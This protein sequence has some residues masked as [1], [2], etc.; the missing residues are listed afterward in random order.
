MS[1][2]WSKAESVVLRLFHVL[3]D[4][5]IPSNNTQLEHILRTVDGSIHRKCNYNGSLSGTELTF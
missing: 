2:P 3:S 1:N 5:K 4:D